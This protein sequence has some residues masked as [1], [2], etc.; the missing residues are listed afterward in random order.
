MPCSRPFVLYREKQI[1][2][3]DN[4]ARKHR[5]NRGNVA[6]IG[7]QSDYIARIAFTY[8]GGTE[9]RRRRAVSESL[10]RSCA[11]RLICAFRCALLGGPIRWSSCS[12]ARTYLARVSRARTWASVAASE[13]VILEDDKNVFFPYIGRTWQCT[14]SGGRWPPNV[15]PPRRPQGR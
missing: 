5:G 12:V 15:K 4:H 1:F 3:D 11:F 10:C 13:K 14:F 6:S 7:F 9:T 8:R 2:V